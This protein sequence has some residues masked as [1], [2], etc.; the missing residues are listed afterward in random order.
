MVLLLVGEIHVYFAGHRDRG[1]IAS[2]IEMDRIDRGIN[3]KR[4]FGVDR[5]R[6]E[7]QAK[8]RTGV[9]EIAK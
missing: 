1:S 6:S 3:V 7:I 2:D 5:N 9:T 4:H 8:L